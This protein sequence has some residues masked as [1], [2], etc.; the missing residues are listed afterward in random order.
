MIILCRNR[1]PSTVLVIVDYKS[2][3]DQILFFNLN[4]SPYLPKF[5]LCEVPGA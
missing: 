1:K 2:R 3:V 5:E 4:I